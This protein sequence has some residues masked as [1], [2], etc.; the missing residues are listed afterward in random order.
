M[1]KR[2]RMLTD[3]DRLVQS[4]LRKS[5]V[6]APKDP[7]GG[8][9][10][11]RRQS[12]AAARKVNGKIQ[13]PAIF[14][15]EAQH[16]NDQLDDWEAATQITTQSPEDFVNDDDDAPEDY[17]AQQWEDNREGEDGVPGVYDPYTDDDDLDDE[18]LES[19]NL[20][21]D[22]DE[23]VTVKRHKRR[24]VRKSNAAAR[25]DMDEDFVDLSDDDDDDEEFDEDDDEGDRKKR[26]LNKSRRV[27]KSR[28]DD[29]PEDDDADDEE[30][31]EEDLKM[32]EKS[33]RRRR[34]VRKALGADAM[35]YVDGNAFIKSLTDAVFDMQDHLVAEVRSLRLENAKLRKLVQRENRQ[36]AKAL[37]ASQM[38]IAGVEPTPAPSV[39][40]AAPMRKSVGA[41]GAPVRTTS[42]AP[43]TMDLTKAFDVLEEAYV[44]G[45]DPVLSR[46][47]TMLEN[48]GLAA[49]QFLSRTAQD[50]LQK[51]NLL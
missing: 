24:K 4:Q 2:N 12:D 21:D 41:Y 45:G 7:N 48:D 46:D 51:A 43:R 17:D 20:P 50:T 35:K 10:L 18:D 44:N 33:Q 29:E 49:V 31:D 11:P 38:Q 9:K 37:V 14:D 19:L 22:D 27:R 5:V 13:Y 40:N 16:S 36:M 30:D 6:V 32:V 26:K 42:V 34:Q 8:A 25:G 28:A 47:I 1:A 15:R 3:F 23:Y 39:Q